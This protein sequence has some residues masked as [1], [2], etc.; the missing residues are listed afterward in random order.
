MIQVVNYQFVFLQ[1]FSYVV[2]CFEEIKYG[3]EKLLDKNLFYLG[4]G[5]FYFM[6]IK[7]V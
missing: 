3:V 2:V 1:G 5:M 4:D 7:R 6:L